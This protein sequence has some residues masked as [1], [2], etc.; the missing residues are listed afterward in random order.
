MEVVASWSHKL[1]V[2]PYKIELEDIRRT[3]EYVRQHHQAYYTIYCVMLETG[4]MFKHLLKMIA[5]WGPSKI[6]EVLGTEYSVRG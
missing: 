3:L 1:D 2:T 5:E 6:V 4:A